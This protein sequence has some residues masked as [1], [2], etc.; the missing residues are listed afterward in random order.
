MSV[1]WNGALHACAAMAFGFAAACGSSDTGGASRVPLPVAGF[2]N[3]GTGGAGGSST[4]GGFG[5]NPVTPIGGIGGGAG[6]GTGNNSCASADVSASRVTP[7]VV[8]VVDGSSSMVA[9]YGATTRW[10]A[11]R[12]ALVGP[13][14]VVSSL[15]GVVK[16][17]LAVYGTIPQCPLPLGLIEPAL[18][19]LQP[20]SAG[21]PPGPPGLTTPT[22]LALQE[23]VN[24]LPDPALALDEEIGPQIIVLATDGDPNDCFLPIPNT[25]PSIDAALAAQAKHQLMYVVSVGNDASAAHLQEMANIGAGMDRNANPGATVYYPEDPA[26]LAS[27]LQSLIG[28]VVGCDV[29]LQGR[30]VVPGGE[31][32]GTVTLN[33]EPLECNGENGWRLVD[34]T[35]IQ[36]QGTA[37]E[38]FK[39]NASAMLRANFPCEVLVE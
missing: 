25:Q 9:G 26:T 38:N 33:G 23:V 17:G 21:L 19:N 29:V 4:A 12:Q 16:F 3:A 34:S 1:W 24:R 8:L 6:M 15:E 11:V 30:G 10:D 20:I 37:C 18:N 36:L 32:R 27:T 2:G 7:S 31:C 14:G 13:S 39:S 35:H 5:P 22:G 28:Q